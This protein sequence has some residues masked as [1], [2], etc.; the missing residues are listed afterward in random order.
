MDASSY[1]LIELVLVFGGFL[2]FIGW[3]YV[4]VTRRIRAREEAAKRQ[5]EEASAR[6]ASAVES[7]NSGV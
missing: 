4:S 2:V 1:A 7:G 6:P 5:A 3:Q